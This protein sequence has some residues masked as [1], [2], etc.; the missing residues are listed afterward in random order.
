VRKPTA[1]KE[2][3]NIKSLSSVVDYIIADF[4]FFHLGMC[5]N[6]NNNNWHHYHHLQTKMRMVHLAEYSAE[7]ECHI[8]CCYFM[9]ASS[10]IEVDVRVLSYD[11]KCGNI[12]LMS[13]FHK[14]DDYIFPFILHSNTDYRLL[15]SLL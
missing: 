11:G 6:N 14:K 15:I 7:L 10:D 5:N 2:E 4:L 9:C 12:I 3:G 8:G 1:H 13:N